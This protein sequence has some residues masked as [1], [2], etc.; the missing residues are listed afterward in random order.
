MILKQFAVA[1]AGILAALSATPYMEVALIGAL[2]P[3]VSG[4]AIMALYNS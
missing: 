2:I 4:C 3:A 1:L